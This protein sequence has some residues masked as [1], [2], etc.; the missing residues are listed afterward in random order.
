M[1]LADMRDINGHGIYCTKAHKEAGNFQTEIVTD[2][3]EGLQFADNMTLA[4]QMVIPHTFDECGLRFVSDPTVGKGMPVNDM[5]LNL[6][7]SVDGEELFVN[8]EHRD[9]FCNGMLDHTAQLNFFLN[10]LQNSYGR[11]RLGL[12]GLS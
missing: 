1:N 11:P 9:A 8:P 6:S 7:V 10:R 3:A 4:T 2:K 5:H 12:K